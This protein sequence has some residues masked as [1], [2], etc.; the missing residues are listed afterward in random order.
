MNILITI[1]AR[2][3][4]KG[5]PRKNI[6]SI[7]GD[8]LIAHSIKFANNI[9]KNLNTTIALS[10]DDYEI[11]KI[12]EKFNLFTDY[13][14]PQKFSMDQA[15]KVL[16]IGHLLNH[17]E[18]KTDKIFDYILDLDVSS[19]IRTKNDVEEAFDRFKKDK[20]AESLF[21]VNPSKRNPYYNMVERKKNGYFSTI[22]KPKNSI[23][24][25]QMAPK[26][27]D[28]NASFYWYRRSFFYQK[29]DTP[30]TDK[31]LIYEMKHVC[32]DL[33]YEEDLDYMK[34]LFKKGEIDF[35]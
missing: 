17:Y 14:R 12:A 3:G 28:M 9:L 24:A 1:C 8:Y 27:Y 4:S 7:G 32:F 34:Y 5:I 19:P 26:T 33:D 10:T 23:I 31:S 29:Y 21:S 25:R 13:V 6:V 11:K 15:S 16:T 18:L 22:K 20:N 30:I 35:I 2:G